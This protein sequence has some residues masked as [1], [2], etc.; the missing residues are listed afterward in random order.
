[1]LHI[2]NKS[3]L[4]TKTLDSCLRVAAGAEDDAIL[5]VEDAVYAATQ[6]NVVA[7][8]IAQRAQAMRVYALRPDLEARGMHERVIEGINL[9]D[10]GGFVDLVAEHSSVQSWL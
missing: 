2:V 9:V 7:S 3:P 5:L 10:Y 1:M 6:G 8:E 4:Q